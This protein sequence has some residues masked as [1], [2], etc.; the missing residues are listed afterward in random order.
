MNI[1]LVSAFPPS[2]EALNEY[3]YHLALEL[4][5]IP[6]LSLTIL[7]DDLP[8]PQSELHGFSV[9]RCWAFN[10]MANP[11]RLL[12]A[13]RQLKPD[14]VWFNLGFAS[15]GGKPLPAFAGI[16]IPAMARMSGFYTHV[17]LHQ[18]METVDLK[19]AGVRFPGLYRAAGFMATQLLL[20][21]NSISV[22]LP[23]YRSIIREKYGRGA[24][25]VRNHGILSGKPE[26]PALSKRGNPEHRILAFGKWGT[27]KKLELMVEAFEPVARK[28]PQARLVVGGTD[29]PKAPGYMESMARRCREHPQ[30]EFIGYVPEDKIAELFQ[31]TSI[32]VMPY[33][34]SAGS[35]GVAHLAC[36][37]GVPI[38]ASDIP[39]FRQLAEEE[40][41]AIELYEPGKVKSLADTMIALLEN[42]ERQMEMAIQ[43][44]SAA[45]RM[46]MPE[47]IRQYLRT[48]NLQQ[49]LGLLA[50]VSRLRRLPRWLPLRPRLARLAARRFL[51]R[52][53]VSTP[54]ANIADPDLL[55]RKGDQ[56]RDVLIPGISMDPDLESSNRSANSGSLRSGPS[57][58]GEEQTAH[59]N[60]PRKQSLTNPLPTGP[61]TGDGQ[62]RYA[63]ARQKQGVTP[64][65]AVPIMERQGG[66]AGGNGQ[67]GTDSMTS[68]N[69]GRRRERADR[70]RG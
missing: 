37:Y 69:D 12:R 1:C 70:S 4:Q 35:S 56:G 68:W 43:N 34:S 58:A 26:Y 36:A 19:D 3:G 31:G 27:Y 42:P 21:A 39:D 63:E 5:E 13:I 28:F 8:Q 55:D 46:S 41:L 61:A 44:F 29:H 59:Q 62:P 2:R 10:S 49:Q 60:R 51:G 25:Y 57:A 30:I 40:G 65:A 14:V 15:F 53:P 32:A 33:S 16:G 9:I 7:G 23:A 17:T 45:L 18:L 47:I 54:P 67:S 20:F 52:L 6:G 11:W 22:L 48:F 66:H 64:P 50:S 38:V 24:V